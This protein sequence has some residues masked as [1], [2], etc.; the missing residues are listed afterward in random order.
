ML[1][2]QVKTPPKDHA[3]QST[4]NNAKARY[5]MAW[6]WHF[7]AGLF[8]VPFMIMLSLTGLV[9]LFDDEIELAR[10][11][12]IIEVQPSD[13][14][15]SAEQQLKAVQAEYPNAN[16]TQFVMSHDP[17]HANRIS[18]AK[19]DGTSV[20]VTINQYTGEVLGEIDRS[21]SWYQLANEIHGTLLIGDWAIVLLKFRPV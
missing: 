21:E 19:E 3:R 10:Y 11:H 9:M 4:S 14:H 5:F 20:L 2:S 15:I 1:G 7:Y 16:I 6:R 18:I 17:E 8:V 13:T 12:S